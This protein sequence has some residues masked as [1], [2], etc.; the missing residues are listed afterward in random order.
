[1]KLKIDLHDLQT[2]ISHMYRFFSIHL[3]EFLS[4]NRII[5]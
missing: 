2:K 3:Y 4:R 1:M 5:F